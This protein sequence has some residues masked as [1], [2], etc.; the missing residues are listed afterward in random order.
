MY[1]EI[2]S[3]PQIGT[4]YPGLEV[5]ITAFSSKP[6]G[7]RMHPPTMRA[8]SFGYGLCTSDPRYKGL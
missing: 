1:Y 6:F 3:V 7:L 2:Q 4:P 5:G 8:E